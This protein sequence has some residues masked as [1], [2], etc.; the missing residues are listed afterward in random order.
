MSDTIEARVAYTEPEV[1]TDD[2]ERFLEMLESNVAILASVEGDLSDLLPIDDN[3][4]SRAATS[5]R[6]KD[7]D[8]STPAVDVQ[9]ERKLTNL[10]AKFLKVE[11]TAITPR[12][13][14]VSLGLDSLRA[15]SLARAL[16]VEG[17]SATPIVIIQSDN[18]RDIAAGMRPSSRST[19]LEDVDAWSAQIQQTLREELPV[20]LLRLDEEDCLEIVG[21]TAL[22]SGMLSQ[23]IYFSEGV[24]CIC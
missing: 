12:S 10:V 17:I 4:S 5:E 19:D 2:V 23:V 9:L 18:I 21:A 6:T 1:T 22:Q 8:V 14:L 20:E 13:S 7:Q 11:I 3:E 24:M 16:A 15:V